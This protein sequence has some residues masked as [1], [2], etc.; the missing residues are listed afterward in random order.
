MRIPPWTL[1]LPSRAPI[2]ATETGACV[3]FVH[4]CG[5][6]SSKG[7]QGSSALRA[8]VDTE[9]L[10][11]NANGERCAIVSKQRDLES[12]QRMPFELV[13]ID[14]DIDEEDKTPIRSCVVKHV[15]EEA[16]TAPQAREF[17]GKA[18]RQLLAA[19]RARMAADKEAGFGASWNYARS[20]AKS[21]S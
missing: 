9:I 10:I 4:H 3:G 8:A 1:G 13:P 12:G 11:E 18:Q 7:A 15:K 17:R 16:S 19:L 6:D 5:K 21:A 2:D 20:D 14:I